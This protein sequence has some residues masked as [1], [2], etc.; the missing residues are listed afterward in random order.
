MPHIQAISKFQAV[1]EVE[2]HGMEE[3][4]GMAKDKEGA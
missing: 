1:E 3:R 4:F 2:E